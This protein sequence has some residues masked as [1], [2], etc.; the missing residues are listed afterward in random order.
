MGKLH[1]NPKTVPI[2]T[3]IEEN[4]V[5]Q[6]GGNFMSPMS[7]PIAADLVSYQQPKRITKRTTR[8]EDLISLPLSLFH[9][10]I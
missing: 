4:V 6:D 2:F 7:Q 10:C 8:F 9:A 1:E 5:S 3:N